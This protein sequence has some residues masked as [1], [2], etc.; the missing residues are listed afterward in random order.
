MAK[1]EEQ[2]IKNREKIQYIPRLNTNMMATCSG[3]GVLVK[4]G[5]ARVCCFQGWYAICNGMQC[6]SEQS[7]E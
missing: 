4:K 7:I 6:Y 2:S 5:V 3:G 1:G